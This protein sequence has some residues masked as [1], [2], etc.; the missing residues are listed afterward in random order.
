MSANNRRPEEVAGPKDEGNPPQPGSLPSI[1]PS[2]N[3]PLIVRNVA[4]LA[5]SK[6]EALETS[7]RIELCR[8]GGSR[9]KPFCDGT[10]ETRGY[11]SE[12][13]ADGT[14]DRVDD[15]AG[16][17]VTVHFNAQQ[18]S[19]AGECARGL[20]SVFRDRDIL[21]KV[22]GKP[23][24][25]PDREDADRVVEVID[26]CPSGALRYTRQGRTGP[27]H[28]DPPGIRIRRDG[29][30]EVRGSIE[31]QT[32]FWPAGARREIYALCR[33]GASRNKPFC[34]GSH[35]RIGFRDPKN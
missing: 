29:P 25:Q 6:G 14:H 9:N 23:W 20:P 11:S 34:D 3:G 32:S 22:M 24:I 1:E 5:N 21:G 26:R 15:F 27:E 16:R 31:L 13:I 28:A 10:H 18:C 12:R 35:H 4:R 2:H 19:G 33:C 7:S 30:Y 17:Q 8:C